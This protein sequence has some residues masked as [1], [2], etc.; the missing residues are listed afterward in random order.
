MTRSRLI[1]ADD[2]TLFRSGLVGIIG[3]QP[4]LEIVGQAED[5]FEAFQLTRE[6]EPDLVIMDIQMPISD[7]I[8]ATALIRSQSP[9]TKIL[10]LTV[11]E[12]Q[13]SLFSAI[14]AGANGYM[15]KSASPQEF[16]KSIR[17][18]LKGEAVIPPG[19][20]AHLLD[21]FARLS[22]HMEKEEVRWKDIGDQFTLTEREKEVL[23]LIADAHSNEKIAEQLTISIHTVKTHVRHILKK[24]HTSNREEAS[25]IARQG[26]LLS[27][28][29][30]Y[31]EGA[32]TED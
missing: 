10:I 32:N 9:Q 31:E 11:Q 21:E 28:T 27:D 17:M 5:G 25:H 20:A 23:S 29:N 18:V 19:L 15:L 14:K 13:D 6:L 1:L 4:D 2:H 7:G 26:G 3:N 16:I 30:A 8:E 24:L 22:S 12:D